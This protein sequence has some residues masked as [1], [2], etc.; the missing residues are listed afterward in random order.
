MTSELRERILAFNKQATVEKEKAKDL[1]KMLEQLDTIIDKI[2]P[3]LPDE[4][5]TILEKYNRTV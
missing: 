1:D 5:K 4:V 2:K 3:F